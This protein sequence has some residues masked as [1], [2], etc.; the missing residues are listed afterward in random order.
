MRA[1]V[2]SRVSTDAQERDG[3]SLETQERACLELAA[4]RGWRVV[5]CIRD[6]ASGGTLERD[7]IEELRGALRRGEADVV[8][9]YAVDRLS[10]SQNHIGILFDEF[11]RAEVRMEFVTERFEDTAVGRFI[12]AA[13]AFIAEVEREKI[14]ERTMR[15]KAERARGGRIPQAFGIGCYGYLYNPAT[16]RRDIEPFQAVVVRRIFERYAESRSYSAVSNELNDASI[17]AFSGGR[18]YPITIRRMLTNEAYTGRTVYR[19]TKRVPVRA[20]GARRRSRVIEQPVDE[21]IEIPGATPA[22]IDMALWQRVQEILNDPE[23]TNRRP[24]AK[25]HYM[26]RGRLRC[27]LCQSAMVGQTLNS[28][29]TP[30]PY[31][32]CRHVYDRTS[33]RQCEGRYVPAEALEQGIWAEIRRVL[34]APE[35]ILREQQ[36]AAGRVVDTDE[37]GALETQLASLRKREE[38]LVRLYGYG[39]VDSDVVRTEL[40][41]VRRQRE[42]LTEEVEALARPQQGHV[43]VDEATL[44]RACA[45]VAE[46]LDQAGA[47]DYERVLEALDISATA[48]RE[49]V[50]VEGTLPIEPPDFLINNWS[51]S[52]L[53]KHRH[54]HVD[55]VVVADRAEHPGARG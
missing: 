42:T 25:R 22:I 50:T 13:R 37:L 4:D 19:R 48:T 1:I 32:R 41:D 11:E 46:R 14:S 17:T 27:G 15:G 24:V 53:N 20:A 52:P 33:S 18:W 26:L 44:R 8:V 55:E 29:A 47:E 6:A 35:L 7:G 12:L 54:H 39:E 5:R 45:A 16:G 2:Y 51:L 28:K 30:Y 23:R 3:T 49:E 40:L 34:T 21:Q 38:R 31:Y 43:S 10:R 36:Q 9:S